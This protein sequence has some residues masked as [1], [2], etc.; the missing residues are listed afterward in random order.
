MREETR[1]EL[2]NRR[3]EAKIILPLLVTLE[4]EA[5]H[6]VTVCKKQLEA[7]EQLLRWNKGWNKEDGE[8]KAGAVPGIETTEST[9]SGE[10]S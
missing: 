6:R 9:P 8:D 7:I 10:T 5:M 1:R 4:Q 3:A 2:E